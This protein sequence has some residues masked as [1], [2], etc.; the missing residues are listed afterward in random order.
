MK[1]FLFLVVLITNTIA[2]PQ[3]KFFQNGYDLEC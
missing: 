2:T 3:Q 1:T